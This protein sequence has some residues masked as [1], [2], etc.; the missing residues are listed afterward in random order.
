MSTLDARKN[1]AIAEVSTGYSAG[2]TSVALASGKGALFPQPST[3]GAFNVVWWNFTDYPNPSD[4]PNKEIVRVTARSTDTLTVTRAQEGT[5]A[6]A[7]NTLG[8]TYRMM[9]APTQKMI[10]DIESKLDVNT[11]AIV[12]AEANTAAVASD[13]SAHA[14]NTSNP[15][16]VTK[17]QVGL[18]NV[19]NDAQVKRTEMGTALGVA[20]LGADGKVPTSQLP[21]LALT[22]VFVVASQVAQLALT[23]EEGDVAIRSDLNKSYIHNGGVSGTMADWSELL[24]PTDAVLSVNGQTGAVTLTTTNISEGSNLYFTDERAQDAIGSMVDAT[25]VYVDATPRL[26]RAALTGAITASAGSNTTALGSFT[27]AQ[28]DAAVSDGNVLYVGDV[29]QYTDEMAQDAIGAMLPDGSLEYIDATPSLRMNMAHSNTFTASQ[30]ITYASLDDT[31]ITALTILFDKSV[32]IA[33]DEYGYSAFYAGITD[34]S[35]VS[36]EIEDK[37]LGKSGFEIGMFR[38]GDSTVNWIDGLETFKGYTSY[39]SYAGTIQGAKHDADV[40]GHDMTVIHNTAFS[41]D[42]AHLHRIFGNKIDVIAT[43][44]VSIDCFVTRK[45]YGEYISVSMASEGDVD[46]AYG[47]YIK[48]VGGADV[49]YAIYSETTAVSHFN[50]DVEVPDEAYSASGWNGDLTV[51]TKNA[52]RDKIE[53]MPSYVSVPASP[54]ATGTAGQISYDATYWYACV[55]TDTWKRVA[56]DVTWVA[57]DYLLMENGDRFVFESGDGFKLESSI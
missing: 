20:T 40:I 23:A 54:V 47:L 5:L 10:D 14:S 36:G 44:T 19:T 17:T 52:I 28:L 11:A 46:E 2:A 21:A 42:G 8:K 51:A 7:K 15:H 45:L 55:A 30:G 18:G 29:T 22:D 34:A 6:S 13:L 39:V 25:L 9:L 48:D 50:G 27:K 24:T 31:D 4:D 57:G 49:N 53:T 37:S 41:N 16:S 32:A 3:A 26:Q 38:S 43:G 1:F 33:N 56:W 35:T 12:Q